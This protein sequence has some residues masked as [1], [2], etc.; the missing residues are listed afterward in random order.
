MYRLTALEAR[1]P[2]LR[3]QQGRVPSE[4]S[5][6]ESVPGLLL[7]PRGPL[8]RGSGTPTF[9]WRSPAWA[10]VYVSRFPLFIRISVILDEGPPSRPRI[11]PI[12]CK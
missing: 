5:R 7:V 10:S 8:T 3:C 12:I 1:S 2:R 9:T 4:G 6:P 11:N